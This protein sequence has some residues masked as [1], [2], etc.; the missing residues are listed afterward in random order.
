V[1][2]L[3]PHFKKS[4]S[5]RIFACVLLMVAMAAVAFPSYAKGQEAPAK[6]SSASG[7]SNDNFITPKTAQSENLAAADKEDEDAVYK[8]SDAVRAVGRVFH[9]SPEHASIA[10]EDFNFLILAAAVVYFGVKFLPKFFR[11]RKDK[12]AQQLQEA[13]KATEEASE[14]LQAVEERLGRLD[15]EIQELR[16]RAEQDSATDEQRIKASIEE[17]R[18]RIVAAS[19]HEIGALSAAAERNLRRFAAVTRASARLQLTEKDDR[20]LVRDFSS[21]VNADLQGRRN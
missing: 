11:G 21:G 3:S 20:T 10:F 12:I 1:T 7:N 17:E 2:F 16:T 5:S 19:E 13:R 8:K 9:L 14:R 6:G 15:Q 4:A 18:K